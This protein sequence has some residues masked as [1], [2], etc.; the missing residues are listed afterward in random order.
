MDGLRQEI[1]HYLKPLKPQALCEA[2]WMAKDMKKGARAMAKINF[3]DALVGQ[4]KRG[5][6]VT[7]AKGKPQ[8]NQ[9]F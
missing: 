9:N 6:N 4:Q 2:Y 5:Y 8:T 7:A 3:H 1:K